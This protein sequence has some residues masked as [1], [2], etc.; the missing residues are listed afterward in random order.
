MPDIS[1]SS[2][3]N[4]A[5][6]R[7]GNTL[8]AE[9]RKCY[10]QRNSLHNSRRR[11]T[12]NNGSIRR[13][14]W[15]V[16]GWVDRCSWSVWVDVDYCRQNLISWITHEV[17]VQVGILQFGGFMGPRRWCHIGHVIGWTTAVS[18]CCAPF[19]WLFVGSNNVGFCGLSPILI[20]PFSLYPWGCLSTESNICSNVS[21]GIV[22]TGW[23]RW[24]S[25]RNW[26]FVVWWS[27]VWRSWWYFSAGW[28]HGWFQLIEGALSVK[29]ILFKISFSFSSRSKLY[30]M[31]A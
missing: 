19:W 30:D 4:N 24:T 10:L 28:N 22:M 26:W 21:S 27:I 25:G 31:Q 11:R 9:A 16:I 20:N 7:A 17:S 23:W 5:C 18:T 15:W 29:R 2:L 1:A 6:Y 12:G 14:C 13:S 3:W 8:D